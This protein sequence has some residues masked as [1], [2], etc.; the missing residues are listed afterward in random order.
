MCVCVCVCVRVRVR[1]CERLC[2]AFECE[3]DSVAQVE[4][5]KLL[6]TAEKLGVLALLESVFATDGATISSYSIPFFLAGLA[7]LVLIP[8]DNGE[9]GDAR[10][11]PETLDVSLSLAACSSEHS[12]PHT[13]SL[14]LS[15]ARAHVC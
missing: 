5:L 7:T 3:S 15:C 4:S 14:P 8:N 6:S 11:Q 1:A 10:R 13:H 2:A 9:S 12:L